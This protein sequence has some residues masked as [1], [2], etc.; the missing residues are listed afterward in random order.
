MFQPHKF[1]YHYTRSQIL[2]EKILP[3]LTLQMGLFENLNDPRES[4]TWPFKFYSRSPAGN[5][6]FTPSLFAEATNNITQKTIVLCCSKDDPAID[7][8]V[9]NRAIRSGYGHP[10]MWAQYAEQHRGV[11]V[12]LD[13][14]LLHARIASHFNPEN[15]F[16]GTL[17]YLNT[18]QGP[19][20]SDPV[21]PYD[22]FYLE[23]YVRDGMAGVMENHIR[24]FNR[25]LFFTKHQDWRDESEYR[26][27]ARVT[28]SAPT[29]IDI[30]DSLNAVILGHDCPGDVAAKVVDLCKI[31]RTPVYQLHWQ[32]WMMS[33]LPDRGHPGFDSTPTILLD[34]ISF[35][36]RVG[37][38]GVFVQARDQHGNMK[39]L[40]IDN[41]GDVVIAG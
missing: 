17:Q 38:G 31:T 41:N 12:V 15:L 25:E 20:S 27:I 16:S 33:I 36:T 29:L 14:E 21:G 13:Q 30:R 18:V 28:K 3:S 39:P 7:E 32:G 22:L 2:I 4:R 8:G 5:S 1:V 24:R 11:C 37:C 26:W 9:D 6:L 35:S 23:D 40:R 34:G 10:R 19:V